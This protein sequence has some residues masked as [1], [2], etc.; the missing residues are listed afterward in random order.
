VCSLAA[1][2]RDDNYEAELQELEADYNSA[3]KALDDLEKHA[4]ARLAA[5]LNPIITRGILLMQTEV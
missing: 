4:G 5:C 2:Q 1:D 3:T